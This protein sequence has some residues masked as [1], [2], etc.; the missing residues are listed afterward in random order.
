MAFEPLSDED[1]N[2]LVHLFPINHA[3]R[4]GRYPRNP[5][6]VLNAIL[7]VLTQNERWHH[8]PAGMPPAQTC[9]IKY[10]QWRRLGI[11]AR[12]AETLEIHLE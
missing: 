10:L 12:I 5:R 2:R 3:R 6:D 9:Y 1:W 7:W 8:L 11:V 4:Y